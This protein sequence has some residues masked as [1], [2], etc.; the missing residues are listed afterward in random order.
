MR[1]EEITTLRQAEDGKTLQTN[2]ARIVSRF[3][4][5]LA[6]TIENHGLAKFKTNLQRSREGLSHILNALR[7]TRLQPM[8]AGSALY[9]PM[10]VNPTVHEV[11][12]SMTPPISAPD[13]QIVSD[14]N[15]EQFGTE[16]SENRPGM[17][18]RMSSWFGSR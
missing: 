10:A 2:E 4:W 13:I 12:P 9:P 3:G 18:R 15:E 16:Q 1:V 6:K 5:G 7:Q 11:S 17:F 14:G 8:I